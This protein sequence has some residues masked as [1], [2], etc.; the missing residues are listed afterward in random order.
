MDIQINKQNNTKKNRETQA[1][2]MMI[3]DDQM[4]INNDV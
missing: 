1:N 4:L 3:N 2:K